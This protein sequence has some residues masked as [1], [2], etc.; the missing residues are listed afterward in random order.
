MEKT[1]LFFIVLLFV[2]GIYFIYKSV[3]T[4]RNLYEAFTELGPD[5]CPNILI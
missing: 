5:D 2:L 1:K 4:E 3:I